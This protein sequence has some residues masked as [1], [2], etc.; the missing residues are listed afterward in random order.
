MSSDLALALKLQQAHDL[1][2]ANKAEQVVAL[3]MRLAPKAASHPDVNTLLAMANLRLGRLEQAEHYARRAIQGPG[4]TAVNFTNLALVLAARGRHADARAAAEQAIAIDP[5]Y[6]EA[7]LTKANL[8]LD[9]RKTGAILR[10]CEEAMRHG[11]HD[12]L[13]VSYASALAGLGETEKAVAFLAEAIERFPNEVLLRG[14]RAMTYVSLWNADPQT[15]L[16]VHKDFGALVDR[17]RP[18]W[19]ATYEPRKDPDKK[20]RVA[21]VSPDLRRHS[22]AF[23]IEPFLE[24]FDRERFEIFCYSTNRTFDEVSARLKQHASV[25]RDVSGKIEVQ[26][27]DLMSSDHID[28]AID[29]A[30]HTD[31]NSLLAFGLRIAP[32]Q[33]TYCGYPAT[34]GLRQMDWRIVDSYTDPPGSESQCTEK[35]LRLDPCFLCY[36]PPDD[37]PAPARRTDRPVVFGSFNATR[38]HNAYTAS[39][40]ARILRA[41]PGSRLVLKS[42]DLVEPDVRNL[43]LERFA[44]HGVADR[45]SFLDPPASLAAHLAL[46]E[47]ID[48]ALDPLP[49]H[50]TTTTCEALW[51][52]VPVVTMPT[53]MHAGRVGVSLLTNIGAPELIARDEED[54]VRLA[55]ELASDHARLDHYRA[56]L[57][58]MMQASPLLDRPGFARRMEEGLRHM[59]RSWCG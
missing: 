14:L 17:I 11:W 35:L 1:L 28:I 39:L 27:G 25:W 44:A 45:V 9:E 34:T 53:A 3:L 46:Y 41:V 32:V 54:Y 12:Q 15:V 6:L 30:G 40:W 21:L 8:L 23:F 47:N 55:A 13:S 50:G 49:Y 42:Q 2:A 4:A 31:G 29:L 48:V 38:K 16:N 59:W 43:L 10:V 24:H 58:A 18:R 37:S 7:W 20:L 19:K 26:I 57:R 5:T 56:N 51:M 36:R 52:G 22:V 33:A